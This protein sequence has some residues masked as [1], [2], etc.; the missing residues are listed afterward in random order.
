MYGLE[1]SCIYDAAILSMGS[2]FLAICE[3]KINVENV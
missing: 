1:G 3:I 2:N